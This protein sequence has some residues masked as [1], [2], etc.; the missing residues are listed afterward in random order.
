MAALKVRELIELLQQQ[1]KPDDEVGV[2][3]GWAQ[4]TAYSDADDDI[5]LQWIERDGRTTVMLTGYMSNC[6]TE[7][8]FV[9]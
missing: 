3:V 5:R 7:L 4:D 8:E 9:D 6:K 2:S 1:T